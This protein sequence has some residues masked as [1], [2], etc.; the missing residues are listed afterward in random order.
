MRVMEWSIIFKCTRLFQL[1]QTKK[2]ITE[3]KKLNEN[4]MYVR[5]TYVYLNKMEKLSKLIV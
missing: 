4:L 5:S 1:K 3:K 2:N